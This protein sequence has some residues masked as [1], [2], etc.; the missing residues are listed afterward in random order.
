MK[1]TKKIIINADDFGIDTG[2]NN[3]VVELFNK[4]AISSATIMVTMGDSSKEAVALAKEHKIPVGLHFNLTLQHERFKNRRDFEKKY[5]AG[6]ISAEYILSELKKQYNWLVTNGFK[7]TH[8]DSH[9]HIH[10]WPGVF[11]VVATFAKQRN[12]PVRIPSEHRIYNRYQKKIS[13][14]D[15]KQLI[16][17]TA[18][19][20]FSVINQIQAFFIGVR[21][22]KKLVSFFALFPRPLLPE[23]EHLKLILRQAKNK[24][25][26]MCH[27]VAVSDNIENL[28][29]ISDISKKEYALMTNKSFLAMINELNITL[30]NYS[31]I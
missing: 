3:A 29:A 19:L 2:V 9:Q 1:K 25:E 17:K 15:L 20:C 5:L 31:N 21:T 24:T 30:I 4:G 6:K 12:L 10:N 14:S 13:V 18:M 23:M 26:Y 8:I 27:P 16:I 11:R 28:T 7:P 22:N